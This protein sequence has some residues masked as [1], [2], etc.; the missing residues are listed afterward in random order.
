[1][2]SNSGFGIKANDIV[3]LGILGVGVYI[4]SQ[5]GIF[6]V[7]NAVGDITS[8]FGNAISGF[9]EGIGNTLSNPSNGLIGVGAFGGIN[10][11]SAISTLTGLNN[12]PKTTI[13]VDAVQLN[14]AI[15][16]AGSGKKVSITELKQAQDFINSNARN[17]ATSR[18]TI[19]A[20]N[21]YAKTLPTTKNPMIYLN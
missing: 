15:N 10:P 9:G 13:Q 4:L 8:G 2:A 18:Q 5:S 21:A 16:T 3:L 19:D 6:K 14:S 11:I 12:K 7:T 20:I 1:M 17:P